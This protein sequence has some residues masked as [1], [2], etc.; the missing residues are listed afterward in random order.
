MRQCI[1]KAAVCTMAM[2]MAASTLAGCGGKSDAKS[3]KGTTTK[4]SESKNGNMTIS[5]LGI[6]WGFGPSQNSAM[7]KYWEKMLGVNL[8]IEW[9]N[10]EDYDQKV[11]TLI[12]TDS[13]PDVVQ[14]SKLTNGS[15][16]YPIFTQAIDAGSFVDL[17]KYLFNNGKGI[18]ET[19]AVMKNWDQTFW[20]QAKYK[21]GTYILPRSKA[22]LGQNSGLMVRRDL[23]KKY[24]Y[25]KEPATMDELKDW[26]IGLS[27][28]A[29]KGEGKKVYGLDFFGEKFMDDR[30]KAFATA[31]TGQSDWAK[32]ADGNFQ[33]MQFQDSYIDFLNFMKDLYDAGA[34]D[35][36]F[37]LNNSDTSSWKAGN[38][39]GYLAAW[40]NWNQ[41]ADKTSNK[42]FDANVPDTDEAWC[43]MPVK[44]PKAYAVSPNYTDI[45]SCIAISAKCSDAK[46]KKI[47]EVFNGTEETYAGY[48][49][50]M[51]NGVEGVHYKK[52]ADGTINTTGKFEKPRQAGYV[53]GWNQIFLK[54]DA[55]QVA[56]SFKRDGSNAASAESQKR[57]QDLKDFIT[58][59]LSESKIT[60][61]AQN[62]HSDTYD[63]QWSVLT[64]NVDSMCTQYVM[65]KID[66]K[67]WKDFVKGLVNSDDYKAIQKEFKAAAEK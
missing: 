55:D 40:Y 37:A 61:A 66:E 27:Q 35:P 21:D 29:T 58:S 6:D 46:I 56:D 4:T 34:I 41:S 42:I 67:A 36:E 47:L 57:A 12:S 10:Y 13:M 62:L 64:D 30:L 60:N 26:L 17:T 49:S 25:E 28:A 32:D 65:G 24:G 9:V 2:V 50:I 39:V 3:A 15:Y 63:K 38:S 8:D 59:N 33:Y 16:Y 20:D 43:L 19:N 52:E 7:E 11:N 54:K 31:Y 5:V 18:A 23:M 14:I 53:G 22:E 45:D 44:G 1:K 51:Q 48:D